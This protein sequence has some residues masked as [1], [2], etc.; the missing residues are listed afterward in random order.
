MKSIAFFWENTYCLLLECAWGIPKTI[1]FV[2]AK[3]GA[4][5]KKILCKILQKFAKFYNFIN[6]RQQVSDY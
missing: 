3:P 5:D 6:R 4:E 2:Q 1:H